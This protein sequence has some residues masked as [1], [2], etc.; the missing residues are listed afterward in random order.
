VQTSLRVPIED[1]EYMCIMH[2]FEQCR[3]ERDKSLKLTLFY[4]SF[5]S[6][7]PRT[8]PDLPCLTNDVFKG[9]FKL[10]VKEEPDSIR[11]TT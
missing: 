8:S 5:D 9:E 3:A 1:M 7:S 10:M 6:I 4:C 2:I 11:S